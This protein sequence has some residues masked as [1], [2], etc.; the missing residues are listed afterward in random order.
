MKAGELAEVTVPIPTMF[1][2]LAGDPTLVMR[3][4]DLVMLMKYEPDAWFTPCWIVLY[5]NQVGVVSAR[6]LKG[7]RGSRE[8]DN[9][10]WEASGG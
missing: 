4:G 5:K 2:P 7:A 8:V 1:E 9:E 10:S 6:W 3:S